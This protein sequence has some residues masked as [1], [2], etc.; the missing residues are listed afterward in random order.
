VRSSASEEK[1]DAYAR[2][3]AERAGI[4]WTLEVMLFARP[5]RAL[6]LSSRC[7]QSALVRTGA[8]GPG[9][10]LTIDG[11]RRGR[12]SQRGISSASLNHV[13]RSARLVTTQ[14]S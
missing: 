6:N 9:Y 13:A 3:W 2:P 14:L 5:S 10:R 1:I 7:S 11:K 8:K 4:C 12:R